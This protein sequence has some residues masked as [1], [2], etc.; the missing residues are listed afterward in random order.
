[1]QVGFVGLTGM[2]EEGMD[3]GGLYRDA[4]ERAMEDLFGEVQ[5]KLAVL[6]VR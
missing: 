1:L 3:W 4:L 6:D 2:N 5:G